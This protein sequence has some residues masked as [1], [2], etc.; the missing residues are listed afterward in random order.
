MEHQCKY[1]EKIGGLLKS[2]DNFEAFMKEMRDNHLKHIYNKLEQ[3]GQRPTWIVCVVITFL[4]SLCGIL[5]T[6][7][8]N[9][10]GS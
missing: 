9:R 7:I 1:E 10:A 2:T 5:I 8:L 6:I 4:T 3:F